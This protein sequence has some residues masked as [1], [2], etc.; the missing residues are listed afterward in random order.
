MKIAILTLLLFLTAC[1]GKVLGHDFRT[2]YTMAIDKP[3]PGPPVY[4]Q[5]WKDGCESGVNAYS[6]HLFTW[7]GGTTWKQDPNLLND[8]MYMQVWSDAFYYCTFR[9]ETNN[10]SEL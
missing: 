9:T 3:P 4:Q 10:R 2:S 7:T 1:S 5:G 8:K 6:K